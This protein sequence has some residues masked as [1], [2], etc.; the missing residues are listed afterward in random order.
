MCASLSI[1]WDMTFALGDR[2]DWV[3]HGERASFL[4][5][6]YTSMIY[7]GIFFSR[8]FT[9]AFITIVPW[10]LWSFVQIKFEMTDLSS[11]LLAQI[12]KIFENVVCPDGYLQHQ[13]I[14]FSDTLHILYE[15][16]EVLAWSN[17][18]WPAYCHFGLLKLI[19]CFKNLSV[20]LNFSNTNEYWFPILYTCINYNPPIYPVKFRPDQI[21]N[22]RVIAIFVCLNWQ[23]IWKL[24]PSG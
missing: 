22:G 7:Q 12:D 20:R 10:I 4:I 11:F 5:I 24:C 23:N 21:K 14:F 8:Y 2:T 1:R 13:C 17:L 9:H 19:K 3:I 18:K 16:C 6:L 15:S